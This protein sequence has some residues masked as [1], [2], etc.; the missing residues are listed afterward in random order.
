[1][2]AP[3]CIIIGADFWRKNRTEEPSVKDLKQLSA[4]VQHSWS[5]VSHYSLTLVPFNVNTALIIESE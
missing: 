4:A 3:N 5:L 1:M 2:T